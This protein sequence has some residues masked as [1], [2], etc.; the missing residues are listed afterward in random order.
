MTSFLVGGPANSGTTLL[1]LLLNQPGMVCLDEPD[2]QKPEQAHRGVPVLQ[3]LFPDATFP[4]P[5]TRKLSYEEAFD[6]AQ[7]C[8]ATVEPTHFGFKTCNYDFVAFGALYRD[9]GLPVVAIVRDIRDV[10]VRPVRNRPSEEEYN[11]RYRLVWENLGVARTWIRY[12]DLVRDPNAT[13]A[14]V[15]SVLGHEVTTRVAWEPSEVRGDMLKNER[16]DLLRSGAISSARIGLWRESGL[17]LS[18]ETMET[19]RM[20][21]YGD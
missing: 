20:M 13:M 10:L 12:E 17:T 16:H 3:G 21:G 19:A 11:K 14:R 6:V 8:A 5:P 18:E 7:A 2:F 9:A 15:M 4:D 1:T